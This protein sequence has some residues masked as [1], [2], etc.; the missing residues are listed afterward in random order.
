MEM[1]G[2]SDLMLVRVLA[3]M[4][5]IYIIPYFLCSWFLRIVTRKTIGKEVSYTSAFV[6]MLVNGVLCILCLILSFRLN[7]ASNI[8]LIFLVVPPLVFD[9]YV[10]GHYGELR[11]T[12]KLL[13]A[14][15]AFASFLLGTGIAA[16]IARAAGY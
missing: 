12:K 11:K 4:L 13:F 9:Y 1:F 6:V 2:V 10:A 15:F 8:A 7:L 3:R 14:V 5:F 16:C